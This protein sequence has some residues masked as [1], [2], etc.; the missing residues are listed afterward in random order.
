MAKAIAAGMPKLRIEE[1][2]ARTQARIDSGRQTIV[3]VNKYQVADEGQIDV[4]KVDNTAVRDAQIGKLE[5]L[6]AERDPAAVQAALDRA[7]Q[8]GAAATATCS[9]SP[10]MRPAPRRPSAK[11]PMRWK[12]YTAAIRPRCGH[13][14][15]YRQA[16]RARDEEGR[17]RAR[18]CRGPSPR[19][20]AGA[21]ASSSPRWARTAT[22]A[23]QK[24]IAAA[25]ADLGFDV[26]IGPLFSTPEEVARQAVE[27]DVHI[28]WR[29]VARRGAPD[30]GAGA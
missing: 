17:A 20:T 25:F 3:G 15:V 6:R 23:G 11:C 2:A 14:G 18:A 9:S 22:T 10:S 8:R 26:D 13:R 27:N 19:P 28:D 1:A 24:V 16:R 7:D 30:P 21:R 5:R 4:L 12:R 29:V